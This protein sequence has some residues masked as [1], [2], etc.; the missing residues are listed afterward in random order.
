MLKVFSLKQPVMGLYMYGRNNISTDNSIDTL[1][2]HNTYNYCWM[3]FGR[4]DVS[5]VEGMEVYYH[6]INV[7][8]SGKSCHLRTRINI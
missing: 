1:F 8:G 3:Q 7:T 6:Y 5:I 4:K 2:K